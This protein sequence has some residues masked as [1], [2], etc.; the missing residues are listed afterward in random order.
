MKH[1]ETDNPGHMCTKYM[2]RGES[3]NDT[4]FKVNTFIK[5]IDFFI[6]ENNMQSKNKKD[7]ILFEQSL[8]GAN[9][10]LISI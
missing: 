1:I 9:F 10:N 4:H 8:F 6:N 7:L 5:R 3:A 2:K